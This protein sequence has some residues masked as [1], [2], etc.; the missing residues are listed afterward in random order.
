[1]PNGAVPAF[2]ACQRTIDADITRRVAEHQARIAARAKLA[3]AE[4]SLNLLADGDSWF[5]YPLTGDLP[6]SSDII[7]ELPSLIAS[8]PT[9]LNLAHHGEAMTGLMGVTRYNRLKAQLTDPKNGAFDAILFSGGGNDL[10]GDQFRL[11]LRDAAAADGDPSKALDQ[12]A[13][14]DIVGVVL[15]AYHDLCAVRDLA[16]H[17]IPIFVHAYDF[18]RPTGNGVCGVGPWLYPSLKSRGWMDDTSDSQVATGGGIVKLILLEFEQQL[19]A[20]AADKRNN[21]VLV[22]TQGTLAAKEWANELHPTPDGFKK[23]AQ[24]FADALTK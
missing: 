24:K 3:P 9:I 14:S 6:I 19:R 20:L 21:I 1:M 4:P 22:Q 2:Q 5:D 23:I 18:A 11:W 12:Q 16:G 8:A 10:V 7:K 13:L 15:S 17:R